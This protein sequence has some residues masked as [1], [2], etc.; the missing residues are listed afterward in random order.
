MPRGRSR[1]L[2]FGGT[3]AVNRQIPRVSADKAAV[4]RRSDGVYEDEELLPSF[5]S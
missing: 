5:T 2:N 3:Q 4:M 1:C